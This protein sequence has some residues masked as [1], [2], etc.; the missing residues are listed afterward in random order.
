MNAASLHIVKRPLLI[1]LAAAI[2]FYA[3]SFFVRI[4]VD[5]QK[6]SCL[7]YPAYVLL[8]LSRTPQRGAYFEFAT[9][10]LGPRYP[11]GTQFLKRMQGVPGD[12]VDVDGRQIQ[13]NGAF[14]GI[15]NP[16]VVAK[17]H[18]STEKLVRHI[19]IPA[20]HYLMMADSPIAYD[21]RY[22]G[23]IERNQIMA[24]AIPL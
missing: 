10:G 13:I 16:V 12:L 4:G 18:L 2:A 11:D 22:W 19:T 23:L 14:A 24:R 3:A 9:R 15:I 6:Q 17:T 21:G 1:G 7:P 20:D 5:P 8:P